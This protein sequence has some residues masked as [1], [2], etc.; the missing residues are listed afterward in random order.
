M[1]KKSWFKGNLKENKIGCH[2][3]FISASHFIY[4]SQS[5]EILKQ[6]QDDDAFYNGGFTLIELLVVVLIIGILA[7]VAV[8][9]YQ[10]AVARSRYVKLKVA[11][12]SLSQAQEIYYLA[13]GRYASN[14]EELDLSFPPELGCYFV[15]QEWG[16]SLKSKNTDLVTYYVLAGKRYCVVWDGAESALW[17][18]VCQQET[19][20]KT[21]TRVT[22]YI[23]Y[24]Y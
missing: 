10:K 15:N 16:C 8:P 19:G 9:Q 21:G 20:R 6:V 12:E 1:Q 11:G 18:T 13:N 5:G 14:F 3:E 2:A 4:D 7:A 17:H 23:Q 22:S 24:M